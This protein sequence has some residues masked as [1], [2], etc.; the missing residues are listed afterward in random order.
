MKKL[1]LLFAIIGAVSCQEE[2]Q[3]TADLIIENA[4]IYTVDDQ[5]SMAT[6]LVVKEGKIIFIGTQEELKSQNLKASK[7]ID[8]TGKF[9]FPGWIDAHCH[10]YR[11][12]QQRSSQN[13]HVL[14][15]DSSNRLILSFSN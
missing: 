3:I 15:S 10:F 1:L 13:R 11:L 12:G 14:L 2:P 9:V 6:A 8:A 7:T 5:F 4:K